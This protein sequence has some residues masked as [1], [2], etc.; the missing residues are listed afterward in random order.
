MA[1]A[2]DGH[3]GE[4]VP[5]DDHSGDVLVELPFA[6]VLLEGAVE[7]LQP[8]LGSHERNRGVCGSADHQDLPLRGLLE[9][10]R[11]DQRN[12]L[13]G[14][15]HTLVVVPPD[16][17]TRP[18][19]CHLALHVD[20]FLHLLGV[21]VLGGVVVD[22]WVVGD[23]HSESL[24]HA[25]QVGGVLLDEVCAVGVLTVAGGCK[26]VVGVERGRHVCSSLL[27]GGGACCRGMGEVGRAVRE[28][29]VPAACVDSCVVGRLGHQTVR[30]EEGDEGVL[31]HVVVPVAVDP[32][33]AN[34][35]PL[36]VDV[37]LVVEDLLGE[38]GPV[39]SSVALRGHVEFVGLEVREDLEELLEEEEVVVARLCVRD[40]LVLLAV[41]REGVPDAGRGL[42]VDH[43]CDAVPAV[44]VELGLVASR[45]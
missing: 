39:V 1:T 16:G 26:D 13:L 21:H 6:P 12:V 17:V 19:A 34:E 23:V 44:W 41:V 3:E 28:E 14:T 10:L 32:G 20:R 24:G 27:G 2:L 8:A 38:G 11:E 5:V 22:A 35:Q 45:S 33:V 36:H 43:V 42:D 37:V 25:E 31:I 18:F 40:V 30:P 9:E 4:P 7:A 29:V 15:L